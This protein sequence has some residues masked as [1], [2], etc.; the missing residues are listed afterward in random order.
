MWGYNAP[1]KNEGEWITFKATQQD[2]IA[3][4]GIMFYWCIHCGCMT[5]HSSETCPHVA[6]AGKRNRGAQANI[7]ANQGDAAS[8]KAQK[9]AKRKR[10]RNQNNP[11]LPDV[12]TATNIP[13]TTT[14]YNNDDE[15]DF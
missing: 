15:E 9:K 1:F 4:N 6:K 10:K 5:K 14:V 11:A 12:L 3:K 7:A 2:P 8:K 13:Q